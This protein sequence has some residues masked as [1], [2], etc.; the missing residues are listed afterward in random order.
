MEYLTAVIGFIMGFAIMFI[1]HIIMTDIW[2]AR[3][4]ELVNKLRIQSQRVE[5][6]ERH[7]FAVPEEVR[8]V[9]FGE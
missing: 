7:E 4:E 9:R 8:D 3:H 6:I 2:E 5:V 1:I